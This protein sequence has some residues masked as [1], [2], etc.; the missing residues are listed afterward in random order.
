MPLRDIDRARTLAAD[1]LELLRQAHRRAAK[2]V[3]GAGPA[4]DQQRAEL[5]AL[6]AHADEALYEARIALDRMLVEAALVDVRAP[7]PIIAL[8]A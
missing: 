7:R 8:P 3:R 5:L 4:G 2:G 6:V 1:G